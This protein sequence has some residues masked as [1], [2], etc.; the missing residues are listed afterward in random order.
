MTNGK[1]EAELEYA[2]SIDNMSLQACLDRLRQGDE[3][4]QCETSIMNDFA[5]RSFY[6]ERIYLDSG[7]LSLNGG[8]IFHD[9]SN[10][11]GT[12]GAPSFS[13]DICSNPKPK[14]QIH[15]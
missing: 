5:P 4:T 10:G 11:L 14:W 7:K 15:T 12:S 3:Q 13:V 8:I 2:K 1:L 9:I 6:F